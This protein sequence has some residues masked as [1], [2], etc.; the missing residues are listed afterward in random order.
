MTFDMEYAHIAGYDGH[1]IY[2]EDGD[3]Y[4]YFLRKDAHACDFEGEKQYF[5]SNEKRLFV[6]WEKRNQ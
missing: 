2:H 4:F 3:R 1:L 6:K 5:T